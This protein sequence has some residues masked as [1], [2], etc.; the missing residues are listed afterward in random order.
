MLGTHRHRSLIYSYTIEI[1]PIPCGD[2]SGMH[3][4]ELLFRVNAQVQYAT[5]SLRPNQL[6]TESHLYIL[7]FTKILIILVEP[8]VVINADSICT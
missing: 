6:S 5:L 4:E 2:R 3:D 1:P 8:G 7:L